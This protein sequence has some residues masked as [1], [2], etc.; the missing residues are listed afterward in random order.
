MRH[1]FEFSSVPNIRTV[2]DEKTDGDIGFAD[3]ESTLEKLEELVA[4]MERGEQTLEQSLQDFE[5]GVSLTKACQALLEKAEQRVEQLV[6]N[7]S[8][9]D[10]LREFPVEED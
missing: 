3:F 10:E 8:G 4:R 5:R 1:L 9:E 6:K 2:T 7:Q